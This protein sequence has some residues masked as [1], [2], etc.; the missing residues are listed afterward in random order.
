M[1]KDPYRYFRVEARELLEQLGQGL[2]GLERGEPSKPQIAGLLR[3]AHTLK[4]AARVV[5]QRE[6]ADAAHAIEGELAPWRDSGLAVP[7]PY[8]DKILALLDS[9][10]HQLDALGVPQIGRAH[11]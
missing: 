4:G 7:R 2:L 6:I 11:V 1:A 3:L 5:K 9:I 8:I 10:G